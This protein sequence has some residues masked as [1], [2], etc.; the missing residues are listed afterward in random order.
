MNI[1]SSRSSCDL[2]VVTGARNSYAGESAPFSSG[3]PELKALHVQADR[4]SG[5]SC[6][7]GSFSRFMFAASMRFLGEEMRNED[8][9]LPLEV[10]SE[11][12]VSEDVVNL[13]IDTVIRLIADTPGCSNPRSVISAGMLVRL[14]VVQRPCCRTARGSDMTIARSWNPPAMLG[15]FPACA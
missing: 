7:A 12:Q 10:P 15:C 1:S 8:K 9:E 13:L 3:I 2:P 11:Q 4:Y 6:L 5:P 14:R